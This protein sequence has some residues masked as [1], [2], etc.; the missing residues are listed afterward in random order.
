MLAEIAIGRVRKT[1]GIKGYLKI[2]SYSGEYDHFYDLTL[3]T[4]K[5]KERTRSFEIEKVI[6]LGGE[7][8]IKLKGVD[9]PEDGKLLSGWDIWVPR[10]LASKLEDGEFYLADLAG[11]ELIL[12]GKSVGKIRTILN[13]AS[14]DL[15][16]VDTEEGSKLVPFNSV[17]I[18]KIDTDK[19]TVELLE[20]WILD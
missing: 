3:I 10:T 17:F 9:N 12:E 11:S 4:L 7:V 6:P 1:H 13:S 15:L 8:L 5:N 2:M 18:G 20:G 14:D 16:E 19:K